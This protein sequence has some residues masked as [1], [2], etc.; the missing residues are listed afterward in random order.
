MVNAQ[1]ATPLYQ[2]YF[3]SLV[4]WASADPRKPD[5]LLAKAAY[6]GLLG[7]VFDDDRQFESRMAAFLE[8]YVCDFVGPNLKC[9]P[10]QSR[11]EEAL[12]T[13]PAERA[14]AFRAFTETLHALYEVRRLGAGTVRVRNLISKED[15]DVTER[16]HLAGLTKGDV[17]E[18]RLIPFGGNLWFAGAFCCHPPGATKLLQKQAKRLQKAGDAVNAKAFLWEAAK[19]S[20]KADRYR[21]ISIERLYDFDAS[22]P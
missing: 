5:L 10:A 22:V 4:E 18:A 2:P 16:R 21:N 19:R 3:D 6:S 20:L 1:A 15:F 12:R 8:F 7:E 17:L 14:A 11:Y 13:G 9:T